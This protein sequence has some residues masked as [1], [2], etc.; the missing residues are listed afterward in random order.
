MRKHWRLQEVAR[1]VGKAPG[2][3]S[4]GPALHRQGQLQGTD[5]QYSISREERRATGTPAPLILSPSTTP[6]PAPEPEIQ[7]PALGHTPPLRSAMGASVSV[8]NQLLIFPQNLLPT[9]LS[10]LRN[11]QNDS[12][13]AQAKSLEWFRH[14]HIRPVSKV[15]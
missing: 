9:P 1:A 14:T 15:W 4:L 11:R 6:P 5:A 12:Q 10:Q 3:R 8:S 13:A 2:P 7:H